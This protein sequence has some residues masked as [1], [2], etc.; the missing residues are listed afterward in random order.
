MSSATGL[1]DRAVDAGSPS[2]PPA[3]VRAASSAWPGAAWCAAA[4]GLVAVAGVASIAVG[5]RGVGLGE[6]IAGIQG[7]TATIGEAAVAA[8]VPRTVLALVVGAALGLAGATLQGV[9]RNP[10]ADPGILGVNSGAALAVVVGIAFAGLASPGAYVWVAIAGAGATAVFVY[11]VGSLGPRG[12]RGASP[13]RLALAGAAT[14]AACTSLTTAVLLPRIE[15][16]N[17]YRFWVIGGVGGADL[18]RLAT[19]APFLVV[20]ALMCLAS[21]R[22]LDALALGDDAAAALGRNVAATRA[23]CWAGAVVLC[24]A[25]TA[26]AGPLAFVG[27]VVPHIA[28]LLAGHGHQWL[29]PLTMLLG[30]ALLTLADVAGR[31]VA[32]PTEVDV[33]IM[34]ALLGGPVFLLLVRRTTVAGL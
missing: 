4:L 13:L 12:S 25:A 5:A 7:G 26:V 23:L 33:G 20:G 30:A 24:G 28:R 32:P 10:L 3:D 8:R 14:A 17:Q 34:T 2:Q 18:G 22:G 15:V 16:M 19:V 6:I 21:W 29:L 9:T 11:A 27:L 1:R 31:V